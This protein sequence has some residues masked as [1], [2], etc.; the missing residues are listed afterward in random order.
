MNKQKSYLELLEESFPGIKA[1]IIRCEALGFSWGSSRLFLKEE[2]GEV[3]SHV[4]FL[5]CPLF[6]DGR[7]SKMGAIHAICTKSTHRKQGHA[8]QLILEALKWA[9]KRCEFVMLFTEIPAF[10]ERFSFHSIQEYRF[11]LPYKHP[12]GSQS[13]RP[14]IAP[15]DNSLFLH[16]FQEREPLSNHV[17]IK[18]TGVLASFNTLFATYP[19]YWSLYYSPSLDGFISYLLEGSTLHLLDIIAKK[20][21]SLEEI[22]EH[23][24]AAID[25]I[26]FYFS[27][28]R[29]TGRA[30]PQPYLYDKGHLMIHGKWPHTKPFMISPLSRC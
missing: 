29:L 15:E 3:V 30:I 18:D 11:Y 7:W 5:E 19:I 9:K 1:N 2:K 21:P 14:V 4:S 24:P 10:Y 23:I 22:L 16:C 27:S 12:R 25:E 6:I 17:W 13:L 28:D 20:L 26:Y 8:S